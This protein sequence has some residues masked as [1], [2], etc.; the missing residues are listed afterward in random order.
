MRSTACLCMV[1]L[2]VSTPGVAQDYCSLIVR[3]L[4][5][6]GLRPEVP[7]SVRE[8]D[9]RI[10]QREQGKEDARFCNLGIL[11]VT[12]TVGSG[13][14]CNQVEVRDVPVAWKRTYVLHVTYDP[15]ACRERVPPPEPTCEILFRVRGSTGAPVSE[16]IVSLTSP[17]A[18]TFVSDRYGRVDIVLKATSH[19]LGSVKGGDLR[20]AHF[21]FDCSPLE[22]EHEEAITV[23]GH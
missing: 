1:V 4:T 10:E 14:M 20:R 21:A 6:Q 2:W 17:I 9:G 12:V 7:I 19:V 15:E 11:P 16:A 8:H 3:V 5:P 23:H 18:K 22:P 13:S